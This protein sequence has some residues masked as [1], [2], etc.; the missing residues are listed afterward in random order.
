MY[1]GLSWHRGCFPERMARQMKGKQL[2]IFE[3]MCCLAVLCLAYR[4]MAEHP[5]MS[6]VERVTVP[7]TLHVFYLGGARSGS[8]VGLAECCGLK[9][10][11]MVVDEARVLAVN[12]TNHSI[13]VQV[14]PEQAT[15]LASV[16]GTLMLA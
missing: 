9:A 15:R 8:R 10:N 3:V 4:Y 7:V 14:T 16:P 11:P 1:G 2:A 5:P 6:E 13:T 12:Q